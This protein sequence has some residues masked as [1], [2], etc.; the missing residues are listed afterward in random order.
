MTR[1]ATRTYRSLLVSGT[2]ASLALGAAMIVH[3]DWQS[4]L[5]AFAWFTGVAFVLS[6]TRLLA[7][8]KGPA[9]PGPMDSRR[10]LS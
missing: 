2:L 9:W 6:L 5:W 8:D 10:P 7:V 1:S 4:A 3:G